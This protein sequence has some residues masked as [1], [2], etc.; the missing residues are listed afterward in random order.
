MN[1]LTEYQE[2]ELRTIYENLDNG[3]THFE[4]IAALQR[5]GYNP[6]STYEAETLAGRLLS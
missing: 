3:Y 1:K 4:L 2:T 6:M 5:L